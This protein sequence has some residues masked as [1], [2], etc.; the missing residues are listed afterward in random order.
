M[1]GVDVEGVD[2]KAIFAPGGIIDQ[3]ALDTAFESNFEEFAV[4]AAFIVEHDYDI[5]GYDFTDIHTMDISR[6]SN[7]EEGNYSRRYPTEFV[8]DYAETF[9][10]DIQNALNF[11]PYQGY[12]Q[13]GRVISDEESNGAFNS[14]EI[15]DYFVYSYN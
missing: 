6:Q 5:A 11:T 1:E 3:D 15:G 4:K 8:E 2:W 7:W 14:S 12:F 9:F 10:P 13:W